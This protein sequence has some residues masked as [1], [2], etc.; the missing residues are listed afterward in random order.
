MSGTKKKFARELSRRIVLGVFVIL[1]IALSVT[2]YMS[3][4]IV[5]RESE[6]TVSQILN[7]TALDIEKSLESAEIVAKNVSWLAMECLDNPDQLYYLTKQ[8]V[9]R[10]PTVVGCA[11]ALRPEYYQGKHYFAPYTYRAT[12]SDTV[13]SIQLGTD[14]YDYFCMDW[15]LIPSLLKE[16]V[17][18]EPYYD[19]GGIDEMI[20]TYGFPMLDEKGEVLG[21]VTADVSL[22]WLSSKMDEIKPYENSNTMLVSRAGTFVA[23]DSSVDMRGE[24]LMSS[25]I[26]SRND[27]VMTVSREM[28]AGKQGEDSYSTGRDREFAVFGPLSNG[29]ELSI[30]CLYS[31]VLKDSVRMQLILWSLGIVAL[32]LLFYFCKRIIGRSSKPIV[33]FSAAANE[34]AHGDFDVALPDISSEDEIQLLRDSFDEMQTSLKDYITELKSTTAVKE[35][36]ESEL[37]IASSIQMHIVPDRFPHTDQTDLYARIIPAREVGG[38][39]YDFYLKDNEKLY[40]LIGDVSGK[41]VPAALFMAIT[42]SA[43]RFTTGIGM[44]MEERITKMNHVISVGNEQG[45]F[46]TLLAGV[47]NLKTRE[48]R[49]CNAGHNPLVV[50]EP[51]KKPYFLEQNPNLVIGILPGFQYREQSVGLPKG[52]ILVMYTDGVTE[53]EAEDDSQFGEERLLEWASTIS[54]EDDAQTISDSLLSAVRAFT[55]GNVQNDDI[56][57]MTIKI[58]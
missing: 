49:F 23:T 24:S 18:S 56:T 44:S 33:E 47:I 54:R 11:I 41:G 52:T 22:A 20:S 57:I 29:W 10:N 32:I 38:D 28:L 13:T 6:R 55:N 46:V 27:G 8:A 4:S 15:Y 37:N 30:V 39:L 53:A 17:W 42:C 25:A 40:F 9:L 19:E 3:H 43:F 21:V 45:M 58:N 26:A 2:A 51:G 7:A 50:I 14:A 5:V 35:R 31:E 16:P 48:M 36:M 34:I 12:G 1:F